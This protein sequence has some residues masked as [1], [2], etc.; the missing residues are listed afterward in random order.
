MSPA[1]S[2]PE[3]GA[4]MARAPRALIVAAI[5]IA[6]LT[7][8]AVQGAEAQDVLGETGIRG[9][10]PTFVYPVLSRWWREYRA[11]LW[12]GGDYPTA[13]SG[14][15]DPPASS[16][17]EYEPVGS[18]AGTLRLKD[19]AVHFGASDM[20]LRSGELAMLGLVQFPIVIVGVVVVVNIDGVGP[21]AIRLTG[22]VLGD[23]FLGK[24]THWSDPA[25]KALN[26]ALKL[27]DARIAVVHRSDGSGTTFNFTDYLAK[28]SPEWKLRVGSALL[29]PWP[30]GT[31]A[32]GN[33]GVAQAVKR[34][35]N[36][37]GYIDYVDALQTKLSYALVQ[38]R[39][40]R[41]ISPENTSFQAAA[42]SAEWSKTSDFYLLL[43]DVPGDNAYPITATVFILMHRAASPGR[44]RAALDFFRWSLE[45]GSRTA[46]QLG[47][48]PLPEPLSQQVKGYWT[49]TFKTGA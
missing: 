18:L 46:A 19:A 6:V 42:A 47:Y 29:V 26:Q 22:P 45:K 2:R 49:R 11:A 33:E 37:I 24:I 20:P 28:V 14:L 17:L 3:Q 31:G 16:A 21:G 36:S 8:A 12:R 23:I 34:V 27:P 38:N 25:L 41:F 9:A 15:D 40:G 32:K 30:T 44:T 1:T 5:S 4:G 48:V 10:G 7:V 13:N 43:T 35:K 39:A